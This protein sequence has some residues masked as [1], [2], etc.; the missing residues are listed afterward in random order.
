M[1]IFPKLRLLPI[2]IFVA[3]L[4]LGLK[5]NV[6]YNILIGKSELASLIEKAHGKQAEEEPSKDAASD[7]SKDA[8]EGDPA[9]ATEGE[10]ASA[11]APQD[12]D[13][14]P[15]GETSIDEIKIRPKEYPPSPTEYEL[16]NNEILKN[17]RQREEKIQ[18][19]SREVD[20]R[21][22]LL[23]VTEQRIQEKMQELGALRVQLEGL[24]GK[25]SEE[26]ESKIKSLVKIYESM[27]PKDAA[28]IFDTLDIEVLI[29][30][31]DKMKEVKT[32]PI[33]AKM[34]PQKAKLVTTLLA[35]KNTFPE[36]INLQNQGLKR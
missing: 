19:K 32:A 16:V 28:R 15:E 13:H 33:L 27:K 24:L 4:F 6:M 5:V 29:E 18:E 30:V 34:N 22:I 11:D 8:K 3:V 20:Q 9:K 23:Q 14:A 10:H 12:S 1:S 25:L 36:D 7:P 31:V 26:Q 2:V 21:E 17:L 35:E